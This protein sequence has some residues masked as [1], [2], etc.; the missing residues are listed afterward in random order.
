MYS[1]GIDLDGV[2]ANFVGSFVSYLENKYGK[3]IPS[4]QVTSYYW[5]ETVDWLSETMFW[6]SFHEFGENGGYGRL[7]LMPQAKSAIEILKNNR[8]L[9]VI[10]HRPKYAYKDTVEWLDKNIS[11]PESKLYLTDRPKSE[12]VNELNLES[13]IDDSPHTLEDLAD[14]TVANIYC[15][16]HLYNRHLNRADIKR[17][18]SWFEFLEAE[19][20]INVK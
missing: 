1:V 3:K 8:D 5:Y 13:Y 9:Y 15:Y 6:D 17:V 12:I 16:D 20:L 4:E 7:E 19:L 2:T 14:N 18:T 10:T 11:I